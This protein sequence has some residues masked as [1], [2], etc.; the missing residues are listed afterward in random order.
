MSMPSRRPQSGSDRPSGPLPSEP[1]LNS[2]PSGLG[3]PS[4]GTRPSGPMLGGLNGPP[5]SHSQGPPERPEG[6]GP[7]TSGPMGGPLNVPT[8]KDYPQRDLPGPP[9]CLG[10]PGPMPHGG[11]PNQRNVQRMLEENAALIKTISDY[12]NA[13][14]HKE[15]VHYQLIL[16]SNMM[17]LASLADST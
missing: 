16:H 1:I 7:L 13:G 9:P 2:P 17:Y 12:Q 11:P 4:L 5:G 10:H 3:G 8:P 15:T 14:K 6:H